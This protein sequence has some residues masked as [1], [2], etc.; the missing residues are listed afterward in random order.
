MVY[1]ALESDRLFLMFPFCYLLLITGK[2]HFPCICFFTLLQV[3]LSPCVSMYIN[4]KNNYLVDSISNQ[5]LKCQH[6]Y[7]RKLSCFYEFASSSY[8]HFLNFRLAMPGVQ[9]VV[10]FFDRQVPSSPC[11]NFYHYIINIYSFVCSNT[12]D[13][14]NFS[15]HPFQKDP[16]VK[17]MALRTD[18]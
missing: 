3:S 15:N 13:M 2:K 7:G 5:C 11:R 4:K 9:N 18:N 1:L 16:N 6:N 10:L 12:S 14:G 17:I 8:F